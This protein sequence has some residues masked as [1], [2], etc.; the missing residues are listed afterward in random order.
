MLCSAHYGDSGLSERWH[1]GFTQAA[2]ATQRALAQVSD[3]SP[4]VRRYSVVEKEME[5]GGSEPAAQSNME[6]KFP[7]DPDG[8]LHRALR[9]W[10]IKE[11]LPPRFGER[12]WQ[13][14][15]RQE[16]QA[17]TGFWTQLSN[18]VARAM[19]RPALAVSY[20]T[21]LLVAGLAAG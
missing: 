7:V 13:R 15:A 14:I 1:H 8:L 17:P 20:V 12:V 5:K 16:V 11:P 4:Q 21:L 6:T 9:E 10:E 3:R 2:R 19:A 18:W